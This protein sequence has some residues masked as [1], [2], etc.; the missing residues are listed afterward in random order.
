MK[1]VVGLIVLALLA[2]GAYIVLFSGSLIK[3]AIEAI[4]PDYLGAS[5]SVDE[6]E[7]SLTE[8]SAGIRGLE[9]GNPQGFSGSHAMRIGSARVTLDPSQISESLIVMS[10]VVV[11]GADVLAVAQ[12]SQTNFQKLLE[13]IESSVGAAGGEEQAAAE[14]GE[15][16]FIIDRFR[17]TNA[18]AA[19][20]SDVLGDVDIS[21]PPIE[22]SD[23]GR[24][25][26]GATAVEV[27]EQILEPISDAVSREAVKQGLDIEGAKQNV[28]ER[29]TEK[30]DEGLKSLGDRL[31]RR[32]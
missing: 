18:K 31:K 25:T 14:G 28:R 1:I 19:L 2:V 11:D 23:I 30:L 20:S 5:V 21:I 32:D 9:I 13:N 10:E 27:A 3:D 29:I 8:G 15:T 17:F 22:L 4:G 24:K 12:G 7:L 16:K 26:N 6:V